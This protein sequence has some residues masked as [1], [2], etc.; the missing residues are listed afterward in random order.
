MIKHVV[1]FKLKDNSEENKQKA[2]EIIL[3]M[4]GNVPLARSVEAGTDFLGSDRSYDVI[5]EVILDGREDL[6]DYQ[7]D[8]Y[9]CGVVKKFMHENA[10]KSISI[11]I[12]L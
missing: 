3:S 1:C 9:H 11:D 4:R 2:K 6:D 12:D 10:E 5:L 7:N 8:P